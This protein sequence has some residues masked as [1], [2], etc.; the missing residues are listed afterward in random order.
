M[1]TGRV[2]R[3][4]KFRFSP[5]GVP[6]GVL[7]D[8][9]ESKPG[10]PPVAAQHPSLG[11]ELAGQCPQGPGETPLGPSR[12]LGCPWPHYKPRRGGGQALPCV[13]VHSTRAPL[14]PR[15]RPASIPSVCIASERAD[16]P[17]RKRAAFAL[18]GG[19][20]MLPHG[21][22]I[23]ANPVASSTASERRP[24]E[25][26]SLHAVAALRWHTPGTQSPPSHHHNEGRCFSTD[27]PGV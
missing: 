21:H 10:Q 6:C 24:S 23:D 19:P 20:A 22:A 25:R 18:D 9:P 17:G 2:A 13:H 26:A 4:F 5:R 12:A 27:T 14:R 11:A 8:L 3:R 7:G 15:S 1:L 16:G